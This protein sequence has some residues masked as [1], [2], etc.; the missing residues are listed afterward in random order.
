MDR[1]P[2]G[3]VVGLLLDRHA[4]TE[5]GRA[6]VVYESAEEGREEVRV[7]WHSASVWRVDRARTGAVSDGTQIQA[8]QG[9]RRLAPR[10]ARPG[11]PDWFLQLVFPLRAPVLGRK[12]D[13]YFPSRTRAHES[14]VLVELEGTDDDRRGH[15]IVDTDGFIQEA[16]FLDVRWTLRLTQLAQ[17]PLDD[18]ASLFA[19]D[20]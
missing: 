12:G 9:D 7:F 5:P 2:L 18:P 10:P 4:S 13:D 14:G 19:T 11:H 17:G 16:S 20:A 1:L 8:W 6:V 3:R 15:L